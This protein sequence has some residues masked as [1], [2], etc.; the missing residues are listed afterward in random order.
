MA[1]L[2]LRRIG[3]VT[4]T[5]GLTSVLVGCGELGPD[6]V[7]TSSDDTEGSGYLDGENG[8]KMIN[9]LNAFNGMNSS[10]GL[11]SHNGL[12]SINGLNTVNGFNGTNGFN[13]SNGFNG[14][15]G[16]NSVNGLNMANGLNSLN[17][18]GSLNGL[19]T[20]ASGRETA[21]YMVRCALAA[22]DSVVKQD[23]NGASF[24]F[25]GGI[26]LAP[27]Y[28]TG[29][30]NQACSEAISSCMMAHINTAGIH[31]P[32]W[33]VGP[34]AALGWGQS[35]WFPNREGT[36][37]GQVM[38]TNTSN[39]LDA[40]YCNGP[41]FDSNTVPGR[42]G[43][44]STSV[45]YANAYG[46]GKCSD[47]G[48]CTMN[49]DGAISCPANGTTWTKPV[50]VWR[51]QTFQAE[52]GTMSGGAGSQ[53]CSSCGGGARVSWLGSN[54]WVQF[55]SVK[56]AAS[57][58]NSLVV[59]YTDGDNG[60]NVRAFN[61]SVNGGA[62]QHKTFLPTGGDWDK[63]ASVTISL[64]GFHSGTSNTI[65][66]QGDGSLAV[67]DLD[68]IEVVNST[69]SSGTVNYCDRHKWTAK[70]S[71]NNSDAS[72]MID[73]SLSGRWSSGADQD[74][75]EWVSVDFGGN[76]KLTSITLN[77]TQ[78]SGSD[79]PGSYAVYGSSDGVS[80]DSSAFKTG[81]GASNSTVISFSQR[82]VRAIKIKQTGTSNGGRWWSIGELQTACS[83]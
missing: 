2:T 15:N 24:T 41:A 8:L 33:M 62:A 38:L 31:I 46:N 42:L 56:V 11:N 39:K 53:N 68:W 69:T 17:G 71:D 82:T 16:L 66:F 6:S 28:K 21:S 22:G 67:P 60:S 77:N 55:N 7:I 78:T 18:L 79:Y 30:C 9:G 35:P 61:V 5:M 29:G 72:D 64:S 25:N 1:Y 47:S 26:G 54:S 20:T 40:Y 49:A 34:M 48:K 57:G 76:V 3:W 63:V 75:S 4:A 58:T 70:A 32:L 13:S 51:G 80:F 74:G 81:S 12:G 27:E 37:F 44:Q 14:T 65:R 10:N 73:G 52:D 45:P 23:Q 43:Q 50:T 19:M 83:M 59:Y 36:F